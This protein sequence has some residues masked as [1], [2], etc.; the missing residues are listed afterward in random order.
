[1]LFFH[2][3]IDFQIAIVYIFLPLRYVYPFP[4]LRVSGY[5]AAAFLFL[6]FSFYGMF[7]ISKIK[8]ALVLHLG[9]YLYIFSAFD[10]FLW[11]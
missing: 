10:S 2:N 5:V 4:Q 3:L 9:Y 6:H 1:M 7:L 8:E 11:A